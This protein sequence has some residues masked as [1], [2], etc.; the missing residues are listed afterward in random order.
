MPSRVSH[1]ILAL[2]VGLFLVSLQF[3]LAVLPARAVDLTVLN[4]NDSGP[5]SLRQTI[6]DAMDGDT[7]LFDSS[8]NGQTIT[9]TSGELLITK[10]L[11]INGPGANLLSI[12][13]NNASRIFHIQQANAAISGLTVRN[14]NDVLGGGI[15]VGSTINTPLPATL[16]G[17]LFLNDSNV[18]SNA[19]DAGGGIYIISGTTTISNSNVYSNTALG[20]GGGGIAN[21]GILSLNSS[22]VYSNIAT[23]GGGIWAIAGETTLNNTTVSGNRAWGQG[24][25]IENS[26][27]ALHL[28]HVTI[29]SNTANIGAPGVRTG[30]GLYNWWLN[31][32]TVR[33]SITNTILAGNWTF[34]SPND[35]SNVSGG[36]LGTLHTNG[37]NLVKVPDASC[38][39]TAT[40]DITNTDPSL[41]P[42]Q[43][44]GGATL[45]HA[46]FVGSPAIDHI[47][48]GTNGCGTSIIV[49][50]RGIMRPQDLGCDIGAFEIGG[51]MYHFPLIFKN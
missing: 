47:P 14:G 16:T 25:G 2:T 13:G 7:I 46:V 20:D 11:T 49:D 30:G 39:F 3:L 51:F 31:F 27:P 42:L 26:S 28:T 8:L 34:N 41:G 1:L 44:N 17:T 48:N 36:M 4:T 10:N 32:W 40:G 23:A 6:A 35:C 12:S 50:Q 38:V 15:Q 33:A 18:Y 43:D 45:T 22:S 5:G 29:V 19:A 24:G 9:L 21:G 37:Y